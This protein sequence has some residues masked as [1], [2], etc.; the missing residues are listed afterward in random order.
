MQLMVRLL[1]QDCAPS[2]VMRLYAIQDQNWQE[3]LVKT[4]RRE[5]W[6]F[7]IDRVEWLRF[8]K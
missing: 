8:G 2:E 7:L 5:G 1:R 4:G 6:F 3:L